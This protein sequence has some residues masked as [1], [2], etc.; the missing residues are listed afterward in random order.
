MNQCA[1]KF[2]S[3]LARSAG[4]IAGVVRSVGRNVISS[5]IHAAEPNLARNRVFCREGKF[6]FRM[7]MLVTVLLVTLA[8]SSEALAQA[9]GNVKASDGAYTSKVKITWD[10]V[11]GAV[12]YQVARATSS[13]GTKYVL[14]QYLGPTVRAYNDTTATPGKTYYYFVRALMT[15]WPGNWSSYNTGWRKLSAPTGVSAS[16]LT[17]TTKVYITWN[18]VSGASYYRVYR[19]TSST[20]AKTD[21]GSWQSGRSYNDT[22]ATPGVRY[23]YWVKAAT[24]SSGYRPSDY[25]SYDM[26]RRKLS[27]PT[28]VSASDG[29]Y[30]DKVR[31]TWSSVWGASYYRVFR[32][33]FSTG[34]KRGLGS[35]ETGTSYDDTSATPGVTYYYWV[36]AATS[37]SGLYAS[38]FGS[39]N[40]GW[41]KLSAPT[42]YRP[43]TGRTRTRCALHGTASLVPVTIE[44][45]VLHPWEG[46]EHTS[47][48][49][50]GRVIT[51]HRQH[52]AR[53]T[54]TGSR[55]RPASPAITP[56]TIVRIT[57]V[58][59]S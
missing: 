47:A 6:R 42:E 41:R 10:G 50:V 9:P 4:A 45:A 37:S 52:R 39:Y 36:R 2:L 7:L 49:R 20:G 28:G 44:S 24:S 43:V 11:F 59:A 35:W 5:R 8:A 29:T 48:G 23:Y 32:A 21:L 54:T 55:R 1:G 57:A 34:M 26:G 25:S 53:R 31:I 51:T 12:G 40:T 27:A 38:D 17:Y 22:S 15:L 3:K 58:G 30:T 19:A 46:R 14:D 56:A 13:G 16:V 33:E 18:S